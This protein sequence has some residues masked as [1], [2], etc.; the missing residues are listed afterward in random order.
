MTIDLNWTEWLLFAVAGLLTG[1]IN[2][3][4]GSGSLI[5][6][7]V[8]IFIG[9]LPAPVANGTN[10]IGALLQ[11][12]VGVMA[13]QRKG[14]L[15]KKNLPWLVIPAIFGAGLGAWLAAS[16]DRDQ[17][18]YTIGG[19]MVFMLIVLLVN[20][21]RWINPREVNH[22]RVTHPLN[23]LAFFAIGA[24]GG[25]IQAGVGI[26]LLAGLV[27]SAGFD[28]K[29]AN[30]IK[31]LIVLFFNVPAIIIF[32]YNHQVHIALG[33]AMAIFQATG[34]FIGVWFASQVPNANLWIHRLLILI[35]VISAGKFLGVWD[36]LF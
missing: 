6:L 18:N 11:S 32:F 35:V 12:A 13:F 21:K 2:T 36:A 16:L 26:F 30:A 7:P 20:P 5:T 28:L 25:F 23:A 3:L 1:V 8:F 9:G 14:Q 31:L 17:M 24:Y 34:T 15:P 19:L 27:L 33:L 10:R 22:A 29:Q 4:A